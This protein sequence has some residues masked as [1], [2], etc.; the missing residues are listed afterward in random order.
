VV[1]SVILIDTDI[2]GYGVPF[3]LVLGI[4]AASAA[5]LFLVVGMMLKA[6]KRPVVSG[7]EELL[8]SSG[9]VL[10]DCEREGWA[11]VHSETWRI[12]SA[13]PLKRGQRVRVAAMNGL[14]LDV[15]PDSTDGG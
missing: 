1:G 7:R 9:E 10:E 8:G 12:R 11:R 14:L 15:V 3:A 6:R 13:A 4:A 5:F 2:P